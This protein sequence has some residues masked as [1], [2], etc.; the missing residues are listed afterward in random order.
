MKKCVYC[1]EMIKDSAVKCR[2][3]FKIVDVIEKKESIELVINNELKQSFNLKWVVD[4]LFNY[5]WRINRTEYIYWNI[6]IILLFI[7]T[8]IL[9][10]IEN[11][12][13][14]NIIV[15]LSYYITITLWIKRFHDVNKSWWFYLIPIY[16]FF[17]TYFWPWDSIDNKFWKKMIN[18]ELLERK[19]FLLF[20]NISL[21]L[22][23]IL[24]IFGSILYKAILY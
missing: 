16:N 23:I 21:F 13:V 22:L 24:N 14:I 11:E 7:N 15:I 4:F 10:N 17:I 8:A 2:F 19:K 3:C 9:I 1:N 18:S 5:N 6:M 20:I 12:F